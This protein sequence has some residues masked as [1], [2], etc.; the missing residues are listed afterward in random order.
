MGR[1]DAGWNRR[2]LSL[3]ELAMPSMW[4]FFP[5]GRWV[6]QHL[7]AALPQLRPS[8]TRLAKAREPLSLRPACELT[9]KVD[10]TMQLLLKRE[11][12]SDHR[13]S[14]LTHLTEF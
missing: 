2:Q 7:V 11:V 4:I 6:V 14:P 9:I 13:R 8:E 5:P 3:E 12:I 10:C 1:R